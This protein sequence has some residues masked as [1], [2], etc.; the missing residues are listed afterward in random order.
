[1]QDPHVTDLI[2]AYALGALEPDEVD[3]VERHLATCAACRAELRLQRR[4][5]EELLVAA[6]QR[7]APPRVRQ[8]LLEQIQALKAEQTTQAEQASDAMQASAPP[9]C[10]TG[11]LALVVGAGSCSS[12]LPP[13]C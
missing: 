2:P 4:V 5:A 7:S 6:P 9:C 13:R 12:V 11:A 8:R 1:M 3:A 10:F